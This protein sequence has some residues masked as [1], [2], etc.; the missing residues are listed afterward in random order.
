MARIIEEFQPSNTDELGGGASSVI[1]Y[2]ATVFNEEYQSKIEV[3]VYD[4]DEGYAEIEVDNCGESHFNEQNLR[5]LAKVLKT[6]A[7]VLENNRAYRSWW[8]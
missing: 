8:D 7:D 2:R 3:I 1:E 4:G 5:D 6:F